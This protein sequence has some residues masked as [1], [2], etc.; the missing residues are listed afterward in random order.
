[1]ATEKVSLKAGM[2]GSRCGKGRTAGTAA[3]K[4]S[5]KKR[6]RAADKAACK[7]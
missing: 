4:K 1:M 3:Y 6:R 5:G 7:Q 2:G